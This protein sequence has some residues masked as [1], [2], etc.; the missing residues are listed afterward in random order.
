[1]EKFRFWSNAERLD[2]GIPEGVGVE[3]LF[4]DGIATH[5]HN[6]ISSV[7]DGLRLT[8]FVSPTHS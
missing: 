3:R 1:M 4:N 7:L 6:P 2:S 8:L 5:T